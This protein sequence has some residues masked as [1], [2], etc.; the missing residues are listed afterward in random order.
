MRKSTRSGVPDRT[1]GA[2]LFVTLE[3]CCHHGKTPPCTDAVIAAGFRRVVIGCQDPARHAA[4]RGIDRL[5]VAGIEVEIGV[6]EDEVRRL[7]A[8]FEMLMCSGRPWV[9]AKWAMTLDGR[10]ATATGHSQWISNDESRAEVHRLRGRM[11]AI[12]TGAGTVRRDDPALTARP[13]GPRTALRVVL[14][15]RGTS[16]SADSRLVKTIADAA[17]L[18]VVTSLAESQQV[19]R[20][21]ELG[22]EVFTAPPDAVG[23]PDVSAVLTELAKRHFTNVMIEAGPEVLG[24]FFDAQLIDEVH[25][26]VA[27]KLI[28]GSSAR[29]PIGGS[30]LLRIPEWP[31]IRAVTSQLFGG[32]H[33]IRGDVV[34]GD[35][36]KL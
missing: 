11:D 31:N 4:G 10:I 8:P 2:Q 16:V 1:H 3:P 15:S 20:L 9:H 13:A 29:P 25:V 32:D 17:V 27:P 5:R 14:D 19:Q 21:K 26:F 36:G 33:Y 34:R 28:G 23:R 22:C 7:I 6:C 30:G 12:V 18:V 35:D 24:S